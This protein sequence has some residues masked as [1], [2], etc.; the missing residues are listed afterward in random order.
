MLPQVPFMPL[1]ITTMPLEPCRPNTI[2][3]LSPASLK[4]LTQ[5]QHILFNVVQAAHTEPMNC[6]NRSKD[7]NSYC[8]F[9]IYS[10][11]CSCLRNTAQVLFSLPFYSKLMCRLSICN[12]MLIWVYDQ[13]YNQTSVSCPGMS[14]FFFFFLNL[15]YCRSITID[16]SRD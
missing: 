5:S 13:V 7:N 4:W 1:Q 11:A 16:I 2:L 12:I 15:V 14:F 8:P 10:P 9:P 6:V 3:S